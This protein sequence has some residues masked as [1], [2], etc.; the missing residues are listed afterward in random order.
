MNLTID[1]NGVDPVIAEVKKIAAPESLAK[2]NERMGEGVKSWLSS[3]YRN[4]AES[5]HGARIYL[6]GQAGE[7]NGG[8]PLD[9]AQSLLLK[10]YGGTV[11]AKRA[12]ALTIPVIPEAHGVRAGAY[13]SMTGRKLFTLRK[14]I[15]NLRNS[16]T[17][18]G[19]EPGCLFESDGHGGVRAVYKLKKSQL[20]APW[21]E[22]FPDMEELT[23]IAFK[24]FMDAML[25]DGGGSE[26]WIN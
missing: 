11:T 20:F 14:S 19:L 10:I 6:T 2:A 15:L 23:G 12:Q 7:G 4:K 25:D 3:W 16:M 24:H 17:G 9:L 21:P 22:A 8:E 5:G 13:A 26:D 18:S 1:L